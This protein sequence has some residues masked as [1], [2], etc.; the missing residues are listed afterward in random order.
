MATVDFLES[1]SED[2]SLETS[3]GFRKGNRF[4]PPVCVCERETE[5]GGGERRERL[6]RELVIFCI[7]EKHS[8]TELY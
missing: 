3:S 1:H 5:R 8:N 6:W 2:I 7:L 4:P